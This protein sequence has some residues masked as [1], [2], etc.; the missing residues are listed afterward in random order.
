MQKKI[1]LLI[2]IGHTCVAL[3]HIK[4]D[5]LLE[6]SSEINLE[7]IKFVNYLPLTKTN[8]EYSMFVNP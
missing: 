1:V 8:R 5:F 3:K 6:T 7:F 4:T 2:R